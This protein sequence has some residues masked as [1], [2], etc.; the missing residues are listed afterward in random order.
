MLT[1]KLILTK[2]WLWPRQAKWVQKESKKIHKFYRCHIVFRLSLAMLSKNYQ[3]VSQLRGRIRIDLNA[4]ATIQW[5]GMASASK[6]LKN[7]SRQ[8]SFLADCASGR[9]LSIC[10][11]HTDSFLRV[12]QRIKINWILIF[13]FNFFNFIFFQSE[14]TWVE[15][16]Y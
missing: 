7:T 5:C 2:Q 3:S 14:R 4:A 9:G 15:A 1:L 6:C 8:S 11:V 13:K 10:N 16:H 12:Y